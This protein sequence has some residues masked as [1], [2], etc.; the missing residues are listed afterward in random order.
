MA[1]EFEAG[2]PEHLP[3]DHFRLVVDAF[4]AAVV[5][6]ERERGGG[7]L[8]VEFEAAGERVQVGKVGGACLPDPFQ[9][10]AFVG[11]VGIEHGGEFPDQRWKGLSSPGMRLTA[12]LRSPAA[13][14]R[15]CPAW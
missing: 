12:V 13:R 10:L 5:V 2:A 11:G 7:G 14:R 6:R 9:E 8:D 1:K 3:F 15:G 4:G